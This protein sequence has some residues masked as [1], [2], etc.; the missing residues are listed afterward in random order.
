[1]KRYADTLGA[2]TIRNLRMIFLVV[3]LYIARPD[4]VEYS[5]KNHLAGCVQMVCVYL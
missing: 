2:C 4:S 1:M 3:G 5:C